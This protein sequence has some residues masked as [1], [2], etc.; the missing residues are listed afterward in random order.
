[1]EMC[2]MEVLVARKRT[3]CCD[4]LMVLLTADKQSTMQLAM[5]RTNVAVSAPHSMTRALTSVA[6]QTLAARRGDILFL[7]MEEQAFFINKEKDHLD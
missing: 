4:N 2:C 5:V 1:M 6:P 3:V 7:E